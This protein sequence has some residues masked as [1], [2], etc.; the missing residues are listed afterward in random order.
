MPIAGAAPTLPVVD[1]HAP[2]SLAV[3]TE[4]AGVS[5][6]LFLRLPRS[7]V[8]G[9]EADGFLQKPFTA[10]ELSAALAAATAR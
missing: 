3:L 10:T 1:T 2:S 6:S 5:R 4:G 7:T 9:R 8:S